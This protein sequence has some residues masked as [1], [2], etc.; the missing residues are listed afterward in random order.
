MN[1]F[2]DYLPFIADC[3]RG[4]GNPK[5][6]IEVAMSDDAKYLRGESKAEMF[7]VYAGALGDLE[8]WDKAI[9]IVHTLGRSKGLAGEY[10]MRAVQAEQ[11]FLEQAGRSDEAVALDQ[12]LDKLELQYADADEDETSDDLVIEYDMQELNDEL[13][14]KLGI[15]EDDAQYAPEDEDEDDSEAV[16]SNGETDDETQLDAKEAKEGAESDDEPAKDADKDVDDDSEDAGK[17]DG[18]EDVDESGS[19]NE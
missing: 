13:M 1:G 5:K 19:D 9:E 2:L 16:D 14:D 4:V 8:M 7:L 12:M 10:R 11:Y 17:D 15:S 18:P 6:A 3:E